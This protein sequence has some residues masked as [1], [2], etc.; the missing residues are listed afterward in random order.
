M[1][2]TRDKEKQNRFTILG[3]CTVWERKQVQRAEKK[4]SYEIRR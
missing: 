4:G 1:P 3:E 2:G